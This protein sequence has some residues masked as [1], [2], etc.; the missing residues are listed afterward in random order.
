MSIPSCHIT[1]R[2]WQTLNPSNRPE[3]RKFRFEDAASRASAK[4]ISRKIGDVHWIIG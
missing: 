1:M 3:L 2:E 4:D